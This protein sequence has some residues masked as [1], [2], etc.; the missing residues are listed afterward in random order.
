M[1]RLSCVGGGGGD[2]PGCHPGSAAM[3][4]VSVS[5]ST[6]PGTSSPDTAWPSQSCLTLCQPLLDEDPAL[7]ALVGHLCRAR[8]GWA[9]PW[10][11]Q[12]CGCDCVSV[13]H[14]P[15]PCTAL[16][17]RP[18]LLACTHTAVR[19]HTWG[20]SHGRT[21]SAFPHAH[22]CSKPGLLGGHAGNP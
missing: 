2:G 9:P 10:H 14:P 6:H 5:E 7:L 8:S 11:H 4:P 12:G 20:A 1:L 21:R 22:S 16:R 18:Q 19:R 13:H 3:R 17:H 15:I